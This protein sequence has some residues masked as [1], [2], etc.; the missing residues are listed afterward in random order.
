MH[1]ITSLGGKCAD[2]GG[3]I[4]LRTTSTTSGYHPWFIFVAGFLLGGWLATLGRLSAL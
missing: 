1:R 3:H 4:E 2:C